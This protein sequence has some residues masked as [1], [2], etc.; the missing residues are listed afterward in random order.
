MAPKKSSNPG[1]TAR[2]YRK[3]KA[4]Y[5]KKLAKQSKENSKP[6][7]KEYRRKLA[8][9][10]RSAGLMGKGG[11]DMCHQKVNWLKRTVK[12]VVS[13]LDQFNRDSRRN[14]GRNL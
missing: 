8:I 13:P 3:N 2:F 4:A 10:R 14:D 11:K 6:S 1:K 7:N 12:A 5:R 9:A